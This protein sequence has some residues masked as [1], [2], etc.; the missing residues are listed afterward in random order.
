VLLVATAGAS[1]YSERD[2][3]FI[4]LNEAIDNKARYDRQKEQKLAETKQLLNIRLLQPEQEY[5][6]NQQLAAQYKKYIIDSA[7]HYTERNLPIA[8]ALNNARWTMETRLQ[9]VQLY[10]M[11]GMYIEAKSILDHIHK[12]KLPQ[13]MLPLYY[14]TNSEFYEHYAHYTQSNNRY[15]Y[16]RENELYRDSLLSVLD[17]QS[18]KYRLL[19]AQDLLHE[20]HLDTAR[21]LFLKIL[22]ELPAQDPNYALTTYYL[23]AIYQMQGNAELEKRYF[24]LSAIADIKN[25]TKDIAALQSLALV[26]MRADDL[27]RAY[28]YMKSAIDDIMFC[29]VGFRAI[30]LS[31]VYTVINTAYI[32]KAARQKKE[33]QL[34]LLFISLLSFFLIIAVVYVY[35]QM[36][37]LSK[38]RQE[39]Y[40]TNLQLAESNKN[41]RYTNLQLQKV[42]AQLSEANHIKEEYIA[43]FF[44]LCSA[45]IDKLEDYRKTLLKKAGSNQHE[46]VFK[47]LKSTTLADGEHEKLYETFDTVFLNLYPTFVEDFNALLVKNERIKLKSGKLTMELRVFALMRLGITD[48]VKIAGFLRYALSTIHNYR[49]QARN[50]AAVPREHFEDMVM[51]IGTIQ[52]KK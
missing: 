39:L 47:M 42:N 23:G 27:D 19:Y 41:T 5:D 14:E 18:L 13:N 32:D 37:R 50:K 7:I 24:A 38:I 44:D 21:K 34:Y 45:Y 17:R 35:K 16:F 31:S 26:Y 46:E 51:E 22:D 33:L 9:L 28:K 8:A 3:I 40:D 43:H 2:S 25:S 10:S 48:N 36:R 20:N 11:A 49:T 29:N 12:A 1:A 15:L 6:I 30:E 4:Q 52:G